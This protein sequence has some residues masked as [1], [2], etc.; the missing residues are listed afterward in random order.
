MHGEEVVGFPEAAPITEEVCSIKGEVEFASEIVEQSMFI[1][2]AY[3]E[4]D[5]CSE[6][7]YEINQFVNL[8]D[9]STYISY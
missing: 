2:K 1:V 5:E 4:S 9:Q 6:L 8:W 3:E 7:R